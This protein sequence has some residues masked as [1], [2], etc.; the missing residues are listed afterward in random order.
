MGVIGSDSGNQVEISDL[1]FLGFD[2][3]LGVIRI[4]AEA[5]AEESAIF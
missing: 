4:T 1:D 5:I 2:S 3:K